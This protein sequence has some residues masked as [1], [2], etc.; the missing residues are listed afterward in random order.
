[1]SP[2]YNSSVHNLSHSLLMSPSYNSSVHNLSHSLLMSPTYNLSF[3]NLSAATR[4]VRVILL[5]HTADT[6]CGRIECWFNVFFFLT[7][8][9]KI[10]ARHNLPKRIFNNL[11]SQQ[12]FMSIVMTMRERVEAGVLCHN[13]LPFLNIPSIEDFIH[14]NSIWTEELGHLPFAKFSFFQ[15]RQQRKRI[16]SECCNAH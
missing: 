7:K 10:H 15:R 6:R 14:F 11:S 3:H 16:A 4:S 8:L 2:P 12:T 9:W 5:H 13:L 1:M